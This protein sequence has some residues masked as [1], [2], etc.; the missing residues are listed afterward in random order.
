MAQ[1][2][3]PMGLVGHW[4]PPETN[5]FL[6]YQKWILSFQEGISKSFTLKSLSNIHEK[7]IMIFIILW[8]IV[9]LSRPCVDVT[10]LTTPLGYG[11]EHSDKM[12]SVLRRLHM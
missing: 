4:R 11:P 10:T 7:K 9:G 5:R 12:K 1:R 8:K 6:D 2:L 3:G